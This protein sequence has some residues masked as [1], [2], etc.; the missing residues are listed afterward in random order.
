MLGLLDDLAAASTTLGARL[1]LRCLCRCLGLLL[2]AP[3]IL[4]LVSCLLAD[5]LARLLH[6]GRIVV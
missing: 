5:P 3:R 1:H 4:G 6:E 2:R